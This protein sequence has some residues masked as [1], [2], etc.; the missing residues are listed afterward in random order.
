MSF[1]ETACAIG[2]A[3]AA[4]VGCGG[5]PYGGPVPISDFP[6]KSLD[7]K[8]DSTGLVAT[9]DYALVPAYLCDLLD[10]DAFARLNGRSVPLFRGAIQVNP[11]QGD[12]GTV[13]CLPPSVTVD[14]IPTDLSPPWTIEIGDSSE[15]VAAS[16]DLKPVTPAD[17]GPVTNPVLNSWTDTLTIL[18]QDDPGDNVPI[19]A[20]ATLTAS[21]GR[22]A[23]ERPQIGASSLVFPEALD[24][25]SSP[26]PVTVQVVADYFSAAE[27]LGCQAPQCSVAP[28][29]GIISQ[30]TTTTFTI[31]LACQAS[32]G[33]CP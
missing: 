11:P 22:A 30:S 7:L 15:V 1:I 28:E 14:P 27:L 29:S 26:G 9:L 32:Y 13:D 3:A 18:L 6:S 21:N 17:V 33:V 8:Y 23:V 20:V 12:D 4:F 24:P 31:Q 10:D 16:F 19:S 2:L 5:S 25:E